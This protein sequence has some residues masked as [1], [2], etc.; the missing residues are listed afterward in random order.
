MALAGAL[1]LALAVAPALLARAQ[2]QGPPASTRLEPGSARIIALVPGASQAFAVDAAAGTFVRIVVDTGG[3]LVRSVLQYPGDP[4]ASSPRDETRTRTGGDRTP[5]VWSAIAAT[6]GDVVMRV[7]STEASATRE[8]AVRLVERRPASDADRLSVEAERLIESGSGAGDRLTDATRAATLAG[9][10]G[11]VALHVRALEL[12]GALHADAGR[13]AEAE[14]AFVDARERCHAAGDVVC[15]ADA[16]VRL[17]RL[18]GAT[19]RVDPARTALEAARVLAGRAGDAAI[20]ADALVELAGFAIAQTRQADARQAIDGALDLARASGHRR[21]EADA[22]NLAGILNANLGESE[23]SESSYQVALALRRAIGD[24]VGAAQTVS[25]LGALA[26]SQGEF[27]TAIGYLDQA[28]AERRRL[29]LA[30]ATANTLHNLGVAHANV[31]ELET[32]LGLLEEALGIWQK[33]GGRRGEAFALQELGQTYARLGDRPRALEFLRRARPLWKEQGDRRGEVQTVLF[34]AAIQ[35][36]ADEARDASASYDTALELA[37]AGGLRREEGLALLGMAGLARGTG[38]LD[39]ASTRARD[40]LAIFDAIGNRRERGRSLAELGAVHLAAG[41]P[42]SARTALVDALAAL[43][44]VEDRAEAGRVGITLAEVHAR[45]A[46][47]AAAEAAIGQA[48]DRIEAVR[49]DQQ[50]ESL[51]LS[52]FASDRPLYDRAIATL[53]ALHRI[54]PSAGFDARAFTVSERRRARRLLDM[55]AAASPAGPGAPNDELALDLRRTAERIGSK[56]ARLTRLLGDASTP[57]AR[58]EAARRELRDLVERADRLRAE[59]RR[60]HDVPVNDPDVLGADE[61]RALLEPDTVLLEFAIGDAHGYAWALT[62]TQ[63]VSFE[64]PGRSA[65]EPLVRRFITAVSAPPGA[66]DARADAALAAS[67]R[68][69]TAT[70]L[71]PAARLLTGR[72]RLLVVGDGLLDAVPFAALPQPSGRAPLVAAFAVDATPSVSVAAAL[73]E[74][75]LDRPAP[76]DR[77]AV[78]AD[79]VYSAADGRLAADRRGAGADPQA[80]LR[81]RFSR[82]EARAIEQRAPGRSALLLDFDATRARVLDGSLARY[83]YLHLASH[84]VIDERFPQLSTIE[85]SRVDGRGRGQDGAVRLL[86]VYGLSLNAELVVLSACN[87]ALGAPVAGEGLVGFASGF[88]RAGA[89]RVVASLWAVDDRAAAAFMTRF[90]DG[91]LTRRLAPESAFREAQRAMRADPRWRHPR[92]WAAWVLL[93][94]AAPTTPSSTAQAKPLR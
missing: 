81:L 54:E 23:Q 75:R 46:D 25:N 27:R 22:L 66:D 15:E 31:G 39:D 82:E 41:R 61:A 53:M 83:R 76:A 65:L 59:R 93:G 12:A 77:I 73:R 69:L 14:K 9:Q 42:D 60:R 67:G 30:Q 45:L 92:D 50:A 26:N 24:D 89:D 74:R 1:V 6:A 36:D 70:L 18:L 72:T 8:I 11:N 7:S 71:D 4:S 5:V 47:G 85:L 29:G 13:T 21:A 79:P 44:A 90:Y 33:T 20:Q 32:A 37:R 58:V 55:V 86:D 64:V 35:V 56:A 88:L 52:V 63:V 91:L 87:T 28:L 94:A 17:G 34:S 48:L 43:E 3:A 84:A 62:S 19:G 49:R 80:P 57:T 78:V 2:D 10:A 38:A 68:A 40:A 51:N 16:G